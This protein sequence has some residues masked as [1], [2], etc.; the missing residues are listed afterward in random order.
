M[1]T[2]NQLVQYNNGNTKVTILRNGTKI[3]E[4]D[5]TPLPEYPETLDI[6]V[7][8]YCDLDCQWCHEMSNTNGEHGDLNK[9]LDTLDELPAG[10]E[11]ALGGGNPLSHPDLEDFLIKAKKKG[12]ICNITVNYEHIK[13]SDRTYLY[14]VYLIGAGLIKGIGVSLPPTKFD[15]TA[16]LFKFEHVV[17]HAIAGIHDIDILDKIL[18]SNNYKRHKTK[19]LVLGYKQFGRGKKYY[20]EDVKENLKKWDMY[21]RKYFG[22]MILSFDNLAIEQLRIKRFFTDKGWDKFYMGDDGNFSMY[23]DA[24]KKEYARTSRSDNRTDW[25]SCTV[26]EYFKG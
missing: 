3:R 22:K 13:S 5:N 6:K 15:L 12:W 17:F 14:L 10:I 4:Y 19:V 9:L 2:I 21:I 8:N 25:N 18:A 24:V 1:T 7:T 23:V 16:P 20:S 11:I 26:K